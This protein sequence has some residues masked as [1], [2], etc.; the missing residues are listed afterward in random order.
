MPHLSRCKHYQVLVL[1]S[2]QYRESSLEERSCRISD[3]EAMT[4]M[5]SD[6][7]LSESLKYV[8][9]LSCLR[10]LRGFRVSLRY[11]TE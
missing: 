7:G 8:K 1:V 9:R 4:A 2:K 6:V 5:T 11:G 10:D 3:Q